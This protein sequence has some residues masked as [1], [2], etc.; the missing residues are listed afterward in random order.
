MGNVE[1]QFLGLLAQDWI[2]L[3]I[4][5]AVVILAVTVVP[6]LI[7][8]A[9]RKLARRT[10]TT[11]DNLYL[12][13]IR[14]YLR[15]LLGLIALSSATARLDFISVEPK[16]LLAQAYFVLIVAL[17]VIML[18]KLVDTYALWYREKME[19]MGQKGE[20]EAVLL[21]VERFIRALI[22]TV[23]LIVALDRLGINISA[24]VA[25]LGIGGLAISLAAQETIA[26]MIG[27]TMILIDTPFRVGDRIEIQGLETWGDVVEIGLRSTRIRTLDNRLVIVPNATISKNQIVNYSYPDPRYRIES[28]IG[29]GYTSDLARVREIITRAVRQVGVALEDKPVDVLFLTWGDTDM[30]LRVRWWIDSYRDA[31]RVTD[32]VNEAIY[33]ALKG[34]GIDM[35]FP[36][37]TIELAGGAGEQKSGCRAEHRSGDED[38]SH[39]RPRT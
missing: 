14:P 11:Y 19:R 20:K 7:L 37:M 13:S 2:D 21:L 30:Q 10:A 9:L 3:G 32:R 25:A 5:L 36:T 28:E 6:W 12:R 29:I 17:A 26:N 24:L 18:W 1:A 4:A 38:G 8:T 34:A 22:V 27:G 23:G 39:Q 33:I 15:W 31:R 35:P 16:S